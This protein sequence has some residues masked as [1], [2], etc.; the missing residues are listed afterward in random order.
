MSEKTQMPSAVDHCYKCLPATRDFQVQKAHFTNM[1]T[2]IL[3]A[4]IPHFN[5]YCS[6]CVDAI[7]HEQSAASS[8][9]SKIWNLGCIDADPG[10]TQGAIAVCQQ[11]MKCVAI[12]PDRQVPPPR[13]APG[14]QVL[15]DILFRLGLIANCSH[16]V[17]YLD[18]S[19]LNMLK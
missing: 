15:S 14:Y 12:G 4:H 13:G 19:D 5:Q 9:A 18:C 1:V 8:E 17:Q 11:L 7:T 2:H 10:S 3:I 6:K 16:T